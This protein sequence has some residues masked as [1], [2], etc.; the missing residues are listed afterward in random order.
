M[1]LAKLIKE[2]AIELQERPA[3]FLPKIITSLIGSIWILT[4]FYG[5]ETMNFQLIY[6][7]LVL[8]MPVFF[9]GV[10]SPVIV[11]EMVKNKENLV[12]SLKNTLN[13][14]P[15][16]LGVSLLLLIAMTASLLPFYVG[17]GLHILTGSF[18][19]LILG[20]LISLTTV[21]ILIYGIYFLPIT[22]TENKTIDS[23]RESFKTSG[24]NK[25]EV[26]ALL[27]FSLALLGLAAASSGILRS[28]GV[29]GFIIGRLISS[30]IATYTVI[31][32]PKY[33]LEEKRKTV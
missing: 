10:W 21:A 12:I 1:K 16:L 13:Y 22:L 3:M 17:L 2:S 7:G 8:F 9:L 26:S 32:S 31:I 20:G 30:I 14:M 23:F 25:K 24:S 18:A 28:I 19:G 27:L 6:L 4:L 15:R 33:Y 29:A 5:L 11:A